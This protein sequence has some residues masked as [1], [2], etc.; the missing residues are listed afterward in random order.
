[1]AQRGNGACQRLG[2]VGS[3]RERERKGGQGEAGKARDGRM[4]GINVN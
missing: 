3:L 4:C 1:M 2:G